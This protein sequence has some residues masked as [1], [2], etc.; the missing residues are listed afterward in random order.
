MSNNNQTELNELNFVGT[1]SERSPET[2][3]ALADIVAAANGQDAREMIHHLL[4]TALYVAEVSGAAEEV[5]VGLEI[6]SVRTESLKL[7]ITKEEPVTHE[8]SP[9]AH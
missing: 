2:L 8:T 3:Q 4:E 1:M 5:K 9:T 6:T 7:V